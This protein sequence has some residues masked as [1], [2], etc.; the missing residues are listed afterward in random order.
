MTNVAVIQPI[1]MGTDFYFDSVEKKW[2][3]FFFSGN[4]HFCFHS[5][6][7]STIDLDRSFFIQLLIQK[8]DDDNHHFESKICFPL[9]KQKNKVFFSLKKGQKTLKNL[10]ICIFKVKDFCIHP[11]DL[12]IIM[13]IFGCIA[14]TLWYTWCIRKVCVL[15][16]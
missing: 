16:C 14:V 3:K 4:F 12:M 9:I 13:V 11:I 1:E 2:K 5:T 15:R 6:I 8:I 10:K 7:D